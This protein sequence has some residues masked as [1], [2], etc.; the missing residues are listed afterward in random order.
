MVL[1]FGSER[2]LVKSKFSYADN[3]I[4]P[5]PSGRPPA[6]TPCPVLLLGCP[7]DAQRCLSSSIKVR[8]ALLL[9]KV[10]VVS[11]T[12]ILMSCTARIITYYR[13]LICAHILRPAHW[14]E[15]PSTDY[16]VIGQLWMVEIDWCAWQGWLSKSPRQTLGAAMLDWRDIYCRSPSESV[17]TLLTVFITTH[18]FEALMICHLLYRDLGP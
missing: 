11:V 12:L 7:G 8:C 4:D 10:W 14:G 3:S 2:S 13:R 16:R 15:I 17:L 5:C 9:I 6:P 1:V 18:N